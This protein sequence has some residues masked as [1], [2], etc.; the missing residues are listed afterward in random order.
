MFWNF[1]NQKGGFNQPAYAQAATPVATTA[2]AQPAMFAGHMAN[3]YGAYSAGL[4]SLAQAKANERS[5]W[6]GANAMAEAARQGTMGNIGSSMLGAYGG[7]GNSALAAWA[8]NQT[9]YNK[10]ASEMHTANQMGMSQYGQSR[11][12]A[13]G[14][15][16]SAYGD[17]SRGLGGAA[18]VGDLSANF[19][20][21]FGG[22]GGGGSGF[23]ASG[24]GGGLASGSFGG[25]GGGGGDGFFGSINRRTDNSMLPGVASGV[26]GG[27]GG[28]N[29]SLMDT[30]LP[31][32]LDRG[33]DLGRRQIDDQHYS[34]RMM[35]SMMMGQA[36]G[37]I[38]NL[39]GMGIGASM[40]GMNQFY[41][42]Q[43]DP[44]NR[45]NFDGVL[46]GLNSGFNNTRGDIRGLYDN[47]IGRSGMFNPQRAAPV[48]DRQAQID[49]QLRREFGDPFSGET[50]GTFTGPRNSWVPSPGTWSFAG[51]PNE[52]RGVGATRRR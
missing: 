41:G 23:S 28:V 30:D 29:N 52:R 38:A 32:R 47:S 10:A 14:Q 19:G 31:N 46:S 40:A 20:G 17:V 44:R 15:L 48:V 42:A 50:R 33:A 34:S 25:G 21:S 16:G 49:A 45:A 7:I 43:T 36:A 6:Y 4:S 9:A 13:L 27:M 35:P 1:T 12:S 26:F 11:N 2:L 51:N 5:N 37:D 39:G 8:Q 18:A 3:N 22:G 24:P